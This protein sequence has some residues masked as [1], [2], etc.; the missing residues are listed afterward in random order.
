MRIKSA[1]LALSGM[2][3][4]AILTSCALGPLADRAGAALTTVAAVPG[5]LTFAIWK[6]EE[7]VAVVEMPSAC[8]TALGLAIDE[9]ASLVSTL[10]FAASG[11]QCRVALQQLYADGDIDFRGV[12]G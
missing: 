2:I 10:D 11:L 1:L 3:S 5:D 4:V 12:V 8:I 6:G 7:K 9:Q